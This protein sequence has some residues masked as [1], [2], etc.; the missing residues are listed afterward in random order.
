MSVTPVHVP[1][2][3]I[4]PEERNQLRESTAT[5]TWNSTSDKH[6]FK[7]MFQQIGAAFNTL[8][9]E[10]LRRD[11]DRQLVILSPDELTPT[12]RDRIQTHE[13]HCNKFTNKHI[14]ENG[15][16]YSF[17]QYAITTTRTAGNKAVAAGESTSQQRKDK[18]WGELLG[19]PSCCVNAF[20]QRNTAS[21]PDLNGKY[22]TACNTRTATP[23]NN[24]P[25]QVTISNPSP[26]ANDLYDMRNIPRAN[27]R[28]VGFL[29]H[30]PCSYD[31]RKTIQRAK[32]H[33]QIL[34]QT[35]FE[36]LSELLLDWLSQPLTWQTHNG[37]TTIQNP[38]V[39]AE[40]PD[41]FAW[42]QKEIHW[43]NPPN[44][45]QNSPP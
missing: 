36:K 29:F 6:R 11:T 18:T 39:H 23:I 34:T 25:Q 27:V 12:W 14:K 32:H 20:T 7:P 17:T 45:Q 38:Y 31:C 41:V 21:H 35:G 33:K 2:S 40:H 22:I 42:N 19:Y 5:I 9:W 26:Y 10:L 44:W 8:Q 1:E 43:N 13:L 15:D 37:V 28:P 3:N 4:T 16:T 24:N 30:R